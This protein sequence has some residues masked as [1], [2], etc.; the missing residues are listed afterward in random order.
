[1]LFDRRWGLWATVELAG[2]NGDEEE[3]RGCLVGL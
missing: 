1:M 3:N 2:E